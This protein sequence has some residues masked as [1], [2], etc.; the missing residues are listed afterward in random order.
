MA[1]KFLKKIAVFTLSLMLLSQSAFAVGV[2]SSMGTQNYLKKVGLNSIQFIKDTYE[3]GSAGTPIAKIYADDFDVA[4]LFSFGG[5]AV[6]NFDLNSYSLLNV[7]TGQ[8]LDGTISLPSITFASDLNT[9]V[10]RVTNDSLGFVTGGQ[11]QLRLDG[12][13]VA[14]FKPIRSASGSA[15]AL[16]GYDV[17]DGSAIGA[18]IGNINDLTTAGDKIVSFY[19]DNLSTERVNIDYEGSTTLVEKGTADVGTTTYNSP[20]LFIDSSAWDTDD[21]VARTQSWELQGVATSG[22]TPYGTLN[23]YYDDGI[24]SRTSLASLNRFGNFSVTATVA[25][26]KVTTT[27]GGYESGSAT[28]DG[29]AIE[30]IQ[31][32]QTGDPQ[33]TIDMAADATG[34]S[35]ITASTGDIYLIPGASA[36]DVY[37]G[38]GNAN[39]RL[40]MVG[41]NGGSS[42]FSWRENTGLATRAQL[43][44]NYAYDQFA[45]YV[46]ST[47]GNQIVMASDNATS[48]DYDHAAE[49]DFALYIHS[50]EDPDTNPNEYIKLQY[51]STTNKG[52]FDVGQ[53]YLQIS[54]TTNGEGLN[55]ANAEAET[56]DATQ[57]TAMTLATQSDRAYHVTTYVTAVGDD[58]A[59]AASYVLHGTFNNNAGTLSAI[60]ATSQVHIAESDADWDASYDVSGTDIRVRVTGVAATNIRWHVTSQYTSITY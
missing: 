20:S 50:V 48:K 21:T 9:G 32:G 12:T 36:L 44:A 7:A 31:G 42:L 16:S 22:T 37:V 17:S 30:I 2:N 51:N 43:T 8:F 11:E 23:F 26:G 34:N 28:I 13:H 27:T 24:V 54:P 10:Y 6:S 18:R 57:T 40:N 55:F 35:T 38:D 1:M 3:L 47:A 15:L 45:M 4:G 53:G 46:A 59:E 5:T 25:A 58:N 33:L 49:T 52:V 56:T 19:S 60:G 14:A 41:A 29:G 39:A